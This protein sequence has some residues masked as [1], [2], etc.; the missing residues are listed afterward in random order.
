MLD[1]VTA[2]LAKLAAGVAVAAGA[3]IGYI[4]ETGSGD[5]STA[6]GGGI[7][8]AITG[9]AV[10]LIAALAVR[11]V[12]ALGDRREKVASETVEEYRKLAETYAATIA[13]ERA[14]FAA[15]LTYLNAE[16]AALRAELGG[17]S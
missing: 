7:G 14:E 1:H 16:N 11:W 4:S 6:L 13:A 5:P 8:G 12:N 17:R 9:G 3:I 15:R 10:V 2:V